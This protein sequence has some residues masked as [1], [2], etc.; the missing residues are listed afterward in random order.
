MLGTNTPIPECLFVP[1]DPSAEI[2]WVRGVDLATA[3]EVWVP[4]VMA[5]YRLGNVRRQEGFWYRISTGCAVHTDPVEALV[6]GM[7]A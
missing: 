3:A 1:F 4:A 7:K 5:C 2:R 6:R